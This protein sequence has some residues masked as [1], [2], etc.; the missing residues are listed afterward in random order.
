ML[1]HLDEM[2]Y[3]SHNTFNETSNNN[4]SNNDNN[5]NNYND[6]VLYNNVV[7]GTMLLDKFIFL[8]VAFLYWIFI[9]VYNLFIQTQ[10]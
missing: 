10:S 4:N 9:L 7:V 5:I 3:S 6:R 8:L 1:P 2:Q